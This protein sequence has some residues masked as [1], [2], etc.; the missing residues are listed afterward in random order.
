METDLAKN[1]IAKADRDCLPAD[2]ELRTRA[3]DFDTAT[4]GFYANPQTFPVA[5]FMSAWAKAR[6][7]WSAYT[8]EP[9]I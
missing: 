8:G 6:K 5:K 1:M 3:A 7:C 4:A 9:L 2:H